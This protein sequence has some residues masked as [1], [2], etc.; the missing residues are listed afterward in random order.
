M[1][2]VIKLLNNKASGRP[3][4]TPSGRPLDTP[5]G[6]PLDTPSGRPLDTP[7]GRPQEGLRKASRRPL[8]GPTSLILGKEASST[9][10]RGKK[11]LRTVFWRNRS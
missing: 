5:S 10:S 11:G 3:L 9:A 4:D 6:R 2:Y 1:W 8:D 7:S